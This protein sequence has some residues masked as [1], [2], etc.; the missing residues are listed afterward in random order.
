MGKKEALKALGF[1]WPKNATMYS[2]VQIHFKDGRPPLTGIL[3]G[4]VEVVQL[5]RGETYRREEIAQILVM[6][7]HKEVL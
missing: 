1:R 5:D 7:S 3:T 4:T 2:E 6:K